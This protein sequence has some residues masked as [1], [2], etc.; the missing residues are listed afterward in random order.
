VKNG[1]DTPLSPAN[2]YL[3]DLAP[4]DTWIA[5]Y[6]WFGGDAIALQFRQTRTQVRAPGPGLSWLWRPT[7]MMVPVGGAP[8]ASSAGV[9]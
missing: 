1:A 5:Y 2:D 4:G 7:N 3:K 9:S 8:H 6:G